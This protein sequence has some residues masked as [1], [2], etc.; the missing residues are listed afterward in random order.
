[1]LTLTS[2]ITTDIVL[3][4]GGHAHVFVLKAFGMNPMPGVRLTLIAKE[5]AAPYSGMLPGYVAG[6]YT[7]EECQIDLVRLARFANA[8]IIHGAANGIDRRAKSVSIEGRPSLRYDFL[9]IDVGI[10]PLIDDIAGA[11]EHA[12]AVKP[13]SVFA[14]KWQALEAAALSNGGPRQIVVLGGGA[15]GFEIILAARH[16][17]RSLASAAG[18][19]PDAFSFTLIAGGTLLPSFNARARKL[20]RAALMEAGVE[21]IENDLAARISNTAVTLASGRAVAADAVLISTR[22]AAPSWFAHTGMPRDGDG[23]LAVRPTLQLLDDDNVFAVG[24]CASVL[25]YPRPKSGVFAV[26]Q[27]PNVAANLRRRAEGTQARPFVPQKQFLT[28]LS[29]GEKRAIAARGPFA[30]AGVWGWTW[31]DKIDRAFMAK[32]NVA[33]VMAGGGTEAG[34]RCGGCA[35]KVGPQTLARVLD[36]LGTGDNAARDDAA[37]I[38]EGGDTVRL[39][40]VDFFRSFWPDPY[41]LGEI[42]ANHA[43]SD[44]YAM[45]GSAKTAQAIAVLPFGHPKIVEEDLYQLLAGARAVFDR[46]SVS[47]IGG[48]SS[49]GAELAVGF[50]ISGVAGRDRLLRKSGLRAGDKLILTKPIG[51]GI[52]FAAEM[53]GRANAGAISDALCEMRQ[54]NRAAALCFARHGATAATDVTGFGLAGHLIDVLDA[55]AVSAEL[56]LSAVETYR[57]AVRLANE[58]V[59]ST[60]LPDNLALAGCLT[61]EADISSA[62][63]ALLFDPQTSGGLLAGVPAQHAQACIDDLARVGVSHASIIG[64]VIGTTD[65]KRAA[66]RLIGQFKKDEQE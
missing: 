16:R 21:I 9:S 60:L 4:G 30:A 37:I 53:R 11:A 45:G 49:E 41:V 61:S 10:T 6:H 59:A 18:I 5:W 38:D 24:D 42:A 52:L 3:L 25:E 33:P 35:A 65:G 26:R 44:V 27:G 47:L 8:R 12:I 13:V 15:A 46:E 32:F 54:S 48:H 40:T 57:Q 66:V 56:N 31:K 55:S 63:L 1:M 64:E 22:A 23:F 14:P 20:S 17:L 36:R 58:G 39:E 62:T 29:L 43:L 50:A 28:L 7:L 19:A 34:M 51:T 2:P